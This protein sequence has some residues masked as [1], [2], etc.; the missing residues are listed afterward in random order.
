MAT[1]TIY[2]TKD[3]S[4]YQPNDGWSGWDDH[5]PVGLG[6]G[7]YRSLIYF[8]ISFT[9]M[10]GITS[11]TLYLRAHRGASGNHVLG[12]TSSARTIRVAR[13]TS[14]WGEGSDRGESLWSSAE[15]WGWNN[16]ATAFTS[17]GQGSLINSGYTEGTWY[18]VDV[19]TVVT[20]WFN[21]S[22]NYGFI[23]YNSDETSTGDGMEFYSRD[24][25]SGYRPYLEIV[26]STNTAP[27][28][29]TG[30]SPTGDALVNSLVPNLT[31]TRSD[32]DAG[33][34]ITGYQINVYADDGTT[35]IWDSGVLT[36]TAGATTFSKAY[37]GPGLTGSTFYKWTA[38]TKDVGQLW[39]PYASLQRFKVNSAPNPPS[40]SITQTPT[41]DVMTL[42]P[43]INITHSDNDAPDYNMYGYHVS[44]TGPSGVI[45]DSGDIDVS[46]S[47]ASVKSFTYSGPALSWGTQY[48]I[49]A[50]T[51]D[52]NGTWGADNS[53]LVFTTHKTSV[54]INLDP[55]A[56]VI[57]GLVPVFTGTRGDTDD[58][59]AS[60]QIIL[61]AADQ[62]TQVWDSGTISTGITSGASFSKTYS[63]TALAYN[64]AYYYKVR[65]TSSVGGTS[66]YS[67]L[68]SFTTPTDATIPIQNLPTP[69]NSPTN[70]NV[71]SLTPTF[72]G[73]RSTAFTHYQIE[74]YP[75][76]ATSGNLGTPLWD[77]TDTT[78]S[79]ATTFSRVYSGPALSWGT[80][81]KWRVR[82]GAPTLGSWTGLAAFAT[83]QAG[84]A[85]I[86][87]PTANQWI[88][89]STPTISGTTSAS[90]SATAFRILLYEANGTSLKWDS[91]DISQSAST[92]WS[93]VYNGPALVPGNDYQIQAR[94][95][96][97]TGPVGPYSAKQ[98]FH[99]NAAPTAPTSLYP[100]PG[101]VFST[102]FPTFKATFNDLDKTTKGDFPSQWVI[103]IRDNLTDA[104]IQTKTLTTGLT[105]DVNTYVWG[106][107]TGGT[108]TGLVF[109]TDYKWRTYFVDS[110][111]A[112]GATSS[113]QVFRSGQAPTVTITGPTNGSN[114]ATTRPTITWTFTGQNGKTQ[115]KYRVTAYRTATSTLVYDSGTQIG[116]ATSF[117]I[118]TG[119]LQ[120]NT[121]FYDLKVVG[122]D[123]DLIPSNTSSVNVQLMLN[124]P[125]SVE[126]F[127]ATVLED[128]SSIYLN[129]DAS[130]LGSAFVTYVIYRRR[131][132]ED[133]WGMIGTA[134]PESN[135][136]FT[137]YYA[138]QSVQYEYRVT[139]VKSV[140]NEPD[141]ESPD[142][143]I[144]TAAL[145]SDV[146]FVV[147]RDR[148][149][150]HIF[151]LP[152]VDESHSRPV[153]QE[154]FEPLGTNRKTV[155]RGFVLGYEGSMDITWTPEEK[156][157][158]EAQVDY[159]LYDAGPHILKNPFGDVYEVTFG[160][161][162]G[163]YGPV[164]VQ[165][166]TL[167]W[168]EVGDNTHNPTLTPDEF[169]AQ[170][171]A[172]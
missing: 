57:S 1:R 14:D 129:W 149:D 38:R 55:S 90:E 63:G 49:T 34:Y 27:A 170:I 85:V 36:P 131:V 154:V 150:S 10:T 148:A 12:D 29:P 76:T 41:T 67:S 59:I 134:K 88:T 157:T 110:K 73:S 16:R 100:T 93:K 133:D 6:S 31:G 123:T 158:A 51:K 61:Y 107:N 141:I 124:A 21:G 95:T 40:V 65:V 163:K 96:K 122:Y 22:A 94:Y 20:A 155:A 127:S 99:V 114:I 145:D 106:S 80:T 77:S 130:T 50:R 143:D 152:V 135:T 166:M 113:Y 15:S 13:M 17:S 120:K 26:Y 128:R 102:V 9:G 168:I 151:E 3:A 146:W 83:D 28:A 139:V 101:F 68:Q 164:G 162:D 4:M 161:P 89:T 18:S 98:T 153:Q 24:R 97:S 69:N 74:V 125:P 159:L 156:F 142:S 137:D 117:T 33:D 5:H 39:G 25:G 169:L 37:A 87:A 71:T 53:T 46:G 138:G 48:R 167:T 2:T 136:Q 116:T 92:S 66:D 121:E 42:T 165:D 35:L 160:T 56:E 112:T 44:V 118:P 144:A 72:S 47:P 64:T 54:P 109:N 43:T 78:Q 103:E 171:G 111:S 105:S 23:L 126:G 91:G 81:Y 58:T 132:G 147:G 140:T 104:L 60:Y 62:I 70:T 115:S 79:S 32:P 119:Y 108:D 19:T 8:P 30:L 75:S 84:V 11:A 86:S 172:A 7:K 52:Q 45:W 82:V